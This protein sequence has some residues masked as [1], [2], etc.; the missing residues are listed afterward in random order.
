MFLIFFPN[1]SKLDLFFV[2]RSIISFIYFVFMSHIFSE[3]KPSTKIRR[4]SYQA[5]CTERNHTTY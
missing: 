3:M 2:D 4:I 1:R 5:N